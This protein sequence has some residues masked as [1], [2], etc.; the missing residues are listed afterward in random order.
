MTNVASVV[1]ANFGASGLRLTKMVAGENGIFTPDKESKKVVVS[2][3]QIESEG[4]VEVFKQN[5]PKFNADGLCI[6]I[7]APVLNG[8]G[9]MTWLNA[10]INQAQL[11][12]ATGVNSLLYNDMDPIF[13]ALRQLNALSQIDYFTGYENHSPFFTIRDGKEF[14][15][16][17]GFMVA[18]A[19]GS[20]TGEVSGSISDNGKRLHIYSSEESHVPMGIASNKL[21]E[22]FFQYLRDEYGY[23][24]E[25]TATRNSCVMDAFN[26]WRKVGKGEIQLPEGY[27]KVPIIC[28]ILKQKEPKSSVLSELREGRT[29]HNKFITDVALRKYQSGQERDVF[30][31]IAQAHVVRNI[32]LTFGSHALKKPSSGLWLCGAI[33]NKVKPMLLDSSEFLGDL[34]FNG[35][36][37]DRESIKFNSLVSNYRVQGILP[38]LAFEL[39]LAE[40]YTSQNP[41]F[42]RKVNYPE[43][44]KI[45]I[46]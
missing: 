26:F 44:L 18:V 42:A 15:S 14:S 7:A 40:L 3:A 46:F 19:P 41:E 21:D 13:A 31:E 10:E 11:T 29:N 4:A 25:E 23:P 33:V 9:N 35:G 27:D 20:G 8:V 17:K 30:C 38:E 1:A 12:E 2:A 45:E 28:E 37:S 43:D 24:T 39:G 16:E 6:G 22:L 32:G 36:Y 5:V 34:T